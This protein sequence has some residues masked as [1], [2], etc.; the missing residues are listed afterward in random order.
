VPIITPGLGAGWSAQPPGQPEIRY[1]QQRRVQRC[2]RHSG[3][4]NISGLQVAV[5]DVVSMDEFDGACERFHQ[6]RGCSLSQRQVLQPMGQITALGIFENE[7][8]RAAN[9]ADLQDLDNIRVMQ[10]RGG[11]GFAT[12]ARPIVGFGVVPG[13]E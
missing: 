6:L 4:K 1:F 12:E 5:D 8:W 9:L 10:L 11:L 3:E 2:A 13:E 7:E